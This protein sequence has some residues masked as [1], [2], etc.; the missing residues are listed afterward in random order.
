MIDVRLDM[1]GLAADFDDYRQL[2]RLLAE[3]DNPDTSLVAWADR[4]RATFSPSC[5]RCQIG[6]EPGWEVYGRNH[7]GRLRFSVNS[8]AYVFIYS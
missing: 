1:L 6:E 4:G 3:K 8:D 7:G 2:T 5:V